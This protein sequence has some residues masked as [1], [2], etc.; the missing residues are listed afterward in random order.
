MKTDSLPEGWPEKRVDWMESQPWPCVLYPMRDCPGCLV[1]CARMDYEL[2][3]FD[4]V[5]EL[6]LR[7]GVPSLPGKRRVP[8]D[9]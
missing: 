1:I 7:P 8:P 3:E 6:L 5:N 9:E 2:G 4:E